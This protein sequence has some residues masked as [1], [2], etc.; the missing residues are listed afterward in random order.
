MDEKTIK[1][2]LSKGERVILECKEAKTNLPKSVWQTYSAFANT[3]GGMIL[4]GVKENIHE[5][6]LLKRYKI[7]GVDD[8]RQI[9]KE[10]W[11]TLNNNTK[12]NKN[13]LE[14]NNVEVV[15]VDGVQ[16]VCILVP[17]ADWQAKP[18][19]LNDNV[20]KNTYRRNNDGD[21][22]CTEAQVNAMIRDSNIEGND[23]ILIEYYGIDDIDIE[24]LSQYR[25]E[26]RHENST[27]IWN[28]V[29]DKT[30][31]RNL[32]GYTVDRQTGREGLT[33]AGLMMFGKGLAIRDRF[34]NFRMIYLD[35]S[36]LIR[37]ERYKEYITY[38]GSWENNL[39]QFFRIVSPKVQFDIQIGKRWKEKR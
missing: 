19:Y 35:K 16:I 5:K 27:H 11:D 28:R 22:H 33:L 10:F 23:G 21:Y 6:D 26:F 2:T 9:I 25:T 31:L 3:N 4:L 29:D 32:G 17:Q 18:I 8:P 13:I 1:D 38:D 39:Y 14:D 12:V 34:P 15:K 36:H 20:Y 30:F 37:N 24:S 7:I